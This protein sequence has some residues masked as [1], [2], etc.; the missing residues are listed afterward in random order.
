MAGLLLV[1]GAWPV[2]DAAGDPVSGATISFFQPGTTTPKPV[3]S[4]DSLTTSL[5]S[6]LTTNA[7]GEPITLGST[8]AREWWA[9]SGQVYDIR[10]QATGLDR[11]WNGI[12]AGS[13]G[14]GGSDDVPLITSVAV[15]R[16]T[17]WAPTRPDVIQLAYNHIP[18]DG[19]GFFRWD[20][21]SVQNDNNGGT[22]VK[23]DATLTGRWVRQIN[24]GWVHA[25]W[26][27]L[28]LSTDEAT[29]T[30]NTTAMQRALNSGYNVRLPA[31]SFWCGYVTQ[32]TA[33][34]IVEG[35]RGRTLWR[36]PVAAT[37]NLIEVTSAAVGVIWRNFRV[38]GNR[39][40]VVYSYNDSEF[41]VFATDVEVSNIEIKDA[42]SIP[43]RYVGPTHR[44]KIRD[45]VIE[46]CGDSG[47][48]VYNGGL[49][50]AINGDIENNEIKNFGLV[51]EGGTTAALGIG[52]RSAV[53]GW[54]TNKNKI[55]STVVTAWDRLAIEYWTNS[56]NGVISENI[57]DGSVTDSLQFG[58]SATGYGMVVGDNI[59]KGTSKYAIEIVDRC[60]SVTT[61]V[62]R[63]PRGGGIA[64]NLNS[65]H[66]D[67]GDVITVTGNTVEDITTTNVSFAGLVIAGDPGTTPVAITIAGNTFHG[68]GKHMQV[69]DQ[70]VGFNISA[71]TFY[72]TGGT[73]TSLDLAGD[74]GNVSANTFVRVSTAGTGDQAQALNVA[75]T[76]SGINISANRFVGNSRMTNGISINN[77]VS[78][79]YVGPNHFSGTL[80]NSVFSNSTS[81]S[82]V[83]WGGF[84]SQGVGVNAANKVFGFMNSSDNQF[85]SQNV[86][87]GISEYT[88]ANLPT[89]VVEGQIAFA[90][91]GRKTGEG[92]GSGT[93]VLVVRDN[94]N[95]RVVSEALPVV[96]S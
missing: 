33:G 58:I 45:N 30:A 65:A 19:G 23:E 27:G 95:W 54:T 91:N 32:T 59:V 5:G 51:A 44:G 11:S 76:C 14:G 3:Y 64:I 10:I 96:T 12:P 16:T 63:S 55:I 78:N 90:T 21:A 1:P 40:N 57:I 13:E 50:D 67:P 69:D 42:Q 89:N 8:I 28:V 56:N 88:V 77:G 34:Q 53:G 61:N 20:S 82:V 6:V 70:V 29:A 18:G 17:V 22:R 92:A 62:I 31:G 7:A 80:S 85:Q 4:N 47:I 93:G 81:A 84:G 2:F 35:D 37:A 15:L 79:I 36:H 26:F 46:N 52:V 72:N 66:S 94:S 75:A 73:S 86:A 49:G 43:I 71:N 83:I 9:S 74:D 87:L 25:S 60:A 68:T 24:D 48:F 38:D 39:A 41:L